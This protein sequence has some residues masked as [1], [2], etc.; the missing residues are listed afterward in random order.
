M[1]Q[2]AVKWED[3]FVTWEDPE[4]FAGWVVSEDIE[5]HPVSV[6]PGETLAIR[7]LFKNTHWL[8][9]RYKAQFFFDGV[10]VEEREEFLWGHSTAWV[11][12]NYRIPPDTPEGRF[13]VAVKEY[14]E[15]FR[16]RKVAWVTVTH[17]PAPDKGKLSIISNPPR[18][19]VTIDGIFYGT[20]PVTVELY[21][22]WY[23]LRLSLDGF[24]D[25]EDRVEVIRGTIREFS[26]VL[27]PVAEIPWKW[28][29]VGV[30]TVGVLGLVYYFATRHPEEV[31]AAIKRARET[32]DRARERWEKEIEPRAK[33]IAKREYDRAR[34]AYETLRARA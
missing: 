25:I 27:E 10:M 34:Q 18:A 33:E 23:D 6:M 32:M 17:P 14:A 19:T 15:A 30:M 7:G 5:V 16:E 22:G 4:A 29:G 9:A 11:T 21:P 31:G 26:Y 8:P 28:I 3:A 24:K 13:E 2:Q 12:H 1:Q 20:T